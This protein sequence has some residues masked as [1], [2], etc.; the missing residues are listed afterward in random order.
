MA[1]DVGVADA[2]DNG[3]LPSPR[4]ALENDGYYW[5]LHT[6]F[7]G[8][9]NSHGKYIDLHGDTKFRRSE[10]SLLDHLLNDATGLVREQP[11]R[12]RVHV[13]KQTVRTQAGPSERELYS[14][15]DRR[16]FLDLIARL[17]GI[18]AVA[19]ETGSSVWFIGD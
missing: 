10:L 11:A 5:F 17:R 13:G 14:E 7:Q 6:L 8:L 2:E 3:L 12:W 18:V 1:L 19:R 16:E 15:V 9:R 4:A